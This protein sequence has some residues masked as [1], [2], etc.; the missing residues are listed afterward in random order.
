M[1]ELVQ[2]FSIK[3]MIV[4]PEVKLV[5]CGIEDDLIV[6]MIKNEHVNLIE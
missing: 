4:F 6:E 5:D 1:F 2:D 3:D